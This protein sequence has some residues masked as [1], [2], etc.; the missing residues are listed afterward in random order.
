MS[1]PYRMALS[2]K[3]PL[4]DGV[5]ETTFVVLDREMKPT[6][7]TVR[8]IGR[9]VDGEYEAITAEM[10]HGDEK[11]SIMD[12]HMVGLNEWIEARLAS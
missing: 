11:L 6:D 1:E 10:H 9:D 8:Y 3:T 2:K 12:P 5:T 4:E 7:M